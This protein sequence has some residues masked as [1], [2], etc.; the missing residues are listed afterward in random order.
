MICS[1]KYSAAF[2]SAS[3]ADSSAQGSLSPIAD[4]LDSLFGAIQIL[5]V[6]FDGAGQPR[7][8]TEN[9]QHTKGADGCQK[10][11]APK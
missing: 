2:V 1:G 4:S 9:G 7:E 6:D 3:D 8:H 10:W 11:K 5:N